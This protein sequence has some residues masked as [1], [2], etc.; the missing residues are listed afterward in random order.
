MGLFSPNGLPLH[1][2]TH[3]LPRIATH[4]QK[5]K[6]CRI[7]PDPLL[8]ARC[9][10][11]CSLLAARCSLLLPAAAA[12]ILLSAIEIIRRAHFPK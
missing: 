7:K 4:Y 1:A 3:P 11:R 12:A 10:T 5:S 2:I 6:H 9:A 8:A